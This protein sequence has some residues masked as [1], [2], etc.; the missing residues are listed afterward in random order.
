MDGRIRAA[1]RFLDA[2]VVAGLNILVA[3]GTQAGKPR[4]RFGHPNQGASVAQI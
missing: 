3:C 4:I 1:G 2:S